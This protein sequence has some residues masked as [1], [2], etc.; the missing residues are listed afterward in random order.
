MN[1]PVIDKSGKKTINDDETLD[2]DPTPTLNWASLPLKV[3]IQLS[4]LR[5]AGI[6]LKTKLVMA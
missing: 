6:F 3:K 2:E 1:D 4:F 5:L